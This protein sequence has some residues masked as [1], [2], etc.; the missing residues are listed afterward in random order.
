MHHACLQL[1]APN[2][3]HTSSD[4]ER[5]MF[6]AFQCQGACKLLVYGFQSRFEHFMQIE[7]EVQLPHE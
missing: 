7:I 6:A 5:G 4:Q 2:G 1:C 3:N